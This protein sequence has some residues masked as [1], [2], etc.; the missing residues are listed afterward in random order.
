MHDSKFEDLSEDSALVERTEVS[1]EVARIVIR[2]DETGR[3]VQELYA[4]M[5]TWMRKNV[6]APAHLLDLYVRS[7][8]DED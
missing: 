6:P 4:P 7:M 1:T 2:I 3:T 5:R 8:K